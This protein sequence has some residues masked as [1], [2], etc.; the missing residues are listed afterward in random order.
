MCITLSLRLPERL[1]VTMDANLNFEICRLKN[2]VNSGTTFPT[3]PILMQIWVNLTSVRSS[4]RGLSVGL[5]KA[6]NI[7]KNTISARNFKYIPNLQA[8]SR[9]VPSIPS[10]WH[11]HVASV[12]Q[13]VRQSDRAEPNQTNV[14]AQDTTHIWIVRFALRIFVVH[15]C[16]DSCVSFADAG[17]RDTF[18]RLVRSGVL[19]RATHWVCKHAF[20][21]VSLDCTCIRFRSKDVLPA[22]DVTFLCERTNTCELGS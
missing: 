15:T 9:L 5:P 19:T 1:T 20:Y 11:K 16:L 2:K 13:S 12:D 18:Q 10:Y 8:K 7:P 14:F 6:Q 22:A 4:L 17:T 21:R 3:R